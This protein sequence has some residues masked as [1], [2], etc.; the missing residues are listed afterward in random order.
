MIRNRKHLREEIASI[1]E[2]SNKEKYG[3]DNILGEY[4]EW[5][6]LPPVVEGM[7]K[8]FDKIIESSKQTTSARR[9]RESAETHNGKPNAESFIG[10]GFTAA[11]SELKESGY[12]LVEYG[13]YSKSEE[14]ADFMKK[15]GD[16]Y[17]NI[18]LIY[19]MVARLE[20]SYRPGKIVDATEDYNHTILSSHHKANFPESTAKPSRKPVREMGRYALEPEYDSRRSFYHKAHVN[21]NDNE[22]SNKTCESYGTTVA[23]IKNGKVIFYPEWD[24]SAT[25]LRHIKEFLNQNGFENFVD[26]KARMAKNPEITFSETSYR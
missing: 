6:Y 14:Y 3:V 20:H 16:K 12:R 4:E 23:E 10:K 21:I 22:P 24:Y 9:L 7:F 8:K 2:R 15:E 19:E 18:T 1:D 25:T 11:E 5:E 26:S 17:H 13:H